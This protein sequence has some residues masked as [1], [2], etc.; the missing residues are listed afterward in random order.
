MKSMPKIICCCCGLLLATMQ[1]AIAEDATA[2]SAPP[3]IQGDQAVTK[4]SKEQV[5]K[6]LED[7]GTQAKK[8]SDLAREKALEQQ[9]S[10]PNTDT[11]N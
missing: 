2:A 3:A 4:P 1:S 7:L 11:G 10:T 5:E 8:R 9:N 6:R